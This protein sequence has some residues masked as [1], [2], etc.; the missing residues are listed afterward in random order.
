M[1]WLGT[2]AWRVLCSSWPWCNF[3]LLLNDGNLRW[4][5]SE[6]ST[7]T[8]VIVCVGGLGYDDL[9]DDSRWFLF[10]VF[11]WLLL[12]L[13]LQLWSGAAIYSMNGCG[14]MMRRMLLLWVV[15]LLL[16]Q[17]HLLLR[18]PAS[19]SLVAHST[20]SC[21]AVVVATF[22]IAVVVLTS[23]SCRSCTILQFFRF[24][25][26]R[27]ILCVLMDDFLGSW[28]LKLKAKVAIALMTVIVFVA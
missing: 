25:D 1:S 24:T 7:L 12:R 23:A 10:F 4:D 22:L 18:E 8:T 15:P 26:T 11:V 2:R 5:F 6:V 16:S 13:V 3:L 21:F 14:L 17:L 19:H 9:W 28:D 27:R 20:T